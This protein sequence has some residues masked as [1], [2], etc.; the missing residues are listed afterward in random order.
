MKDKYE[1]YMFVIHN[2]LCLVFFCL[3]C[4]LSNIHHALQEYTFNALFILLSLYNCYF[5]L[6]NF[7]TRKQNY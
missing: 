6:D 4:A 5:A 2:R 3:S 7:A 1:L